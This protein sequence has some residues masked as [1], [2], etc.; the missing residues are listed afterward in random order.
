MRTALTLNDFD[1]IVGAV[2]DASKEIIEKQEAKH[3][4]MYI[5]IENAL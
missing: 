2:N 3:G 1:F 5:H 4:Q